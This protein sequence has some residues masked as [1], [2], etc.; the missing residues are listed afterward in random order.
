[1]EMFHDADS[2]IREHTNFKYE[3]L[4]FIH[5]YIKYIDAP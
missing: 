5:I 4:I 3:I 2:T 1:M